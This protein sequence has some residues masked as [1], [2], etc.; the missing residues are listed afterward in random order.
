MRKYKL[1]VIENFSVKTMQLVEKEKKTS[2][3][4]PND[5]LNENKMLKDE[6][7]RQKIQL[8][9]EAL[10]QELNADHMIDNLEN[11]LKFNENE[12]KNF[13]LLVCKLM[14]ALVDPREDKYDFQDEYDEKTQQINAM[15]QEMNSLK[16]NFA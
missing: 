10:Q 11:S 7:T 2:N 4:T 8:K 15:T 6:I 12:R 3:K 14:E 13:Q 1:K 9:N 16:I 5:L